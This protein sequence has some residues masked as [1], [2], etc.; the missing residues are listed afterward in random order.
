[1]LTWIWSVLIISQILTA[2]SF[3]AT[4]LKLKKIKIKNLI[5]AG[6]SSSKLKEPSLKMFAMN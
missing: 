3:F 4:C 2:K 5:S 6:L 1:M